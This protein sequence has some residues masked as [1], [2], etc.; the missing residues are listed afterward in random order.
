MAQAARVI[1][2]PWLGSVKSTAEP[3]VR[4]RP[5][6]L[7]GVSVDVVGHRVSTGPGQMRNV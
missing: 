7:S 1:V 4:L 5:C 2:A 6:A 3:S